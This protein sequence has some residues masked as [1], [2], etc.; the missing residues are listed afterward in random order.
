MN[1]LSNELVNRLS[2]LESAFPSVVGRFQ[3]GEFGPREQRDLARQ[4]VDLADVLSDHADDQERDIIKLPTTRAPA[5]RL[6]RYAKRQV[7]A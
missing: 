1:P 2:T 7:E 5:S 6:S 3:D 4:L